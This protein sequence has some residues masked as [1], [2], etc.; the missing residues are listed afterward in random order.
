[1]D[2]KIKDQSFTLSYSHQP[3]CLGLISAVF[4]CLHD[5]I[6]ACDNSKLTTKA[7]K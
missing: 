4:P 7:I 6:T 3:L 5:K 2:V 1:M